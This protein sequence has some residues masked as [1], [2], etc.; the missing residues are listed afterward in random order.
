MDCFHW[1]RVI[2]DEVFGR[3]FPMLP[4]DHRVFN[5]ARLMARG[6]DMLGGVRT[7][8]PVDGDAVFLSQRTRAHH[9]GVH[10]Y[11]DGRPQVIHAVEG[12]GVILSDHISLLQNGWR[13]DGYWTARP[14]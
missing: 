8:A 7:V 2:Q 9:I 11:L 5:A 4:G 14:D 10:V 6:P 3:V 13:I 1:F 12:S